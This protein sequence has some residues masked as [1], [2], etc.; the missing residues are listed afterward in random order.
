VPTARLELAGVTD[1]DTRTAGCTVNAASFEVTPEK[2]ALMAVVPGLTDTASPGDAVVLPM[3]ATVGIEEFQRTDAVRSCVNPPARPAAAVNCRLVPSAMPAVRGVTAMEV[4]AAEVSVVDPVMVPNDAV[5]TVLP[6]IEG[7]AFAWPLPVT[8]ATAVFDD[9]HATKAVRFCA[10]PF[11]RLPVAINS[12]AVP[13][14]MVGSPGERAMDTTGD[15]VTV[16]EAE[17]DPTVAVMI[18]EPGFPAVT[19][20][21]SSTEAIDGSED[22]HVADAV[23]LLV[24]PLSYIPIT[25]S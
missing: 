4:T 6:V 5:M 24:A 12:T 8:V 15:D 17:T 16:V 13:L 18:A 23:T 2:D 3:T 11:S 7:S 19:K 10:A 22:C 9:S 20:P 25:S 14:A 1:N 21:L